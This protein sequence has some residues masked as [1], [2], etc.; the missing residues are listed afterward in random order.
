MAQLIV[1]GILLGGVYA[2]I[3][4]GLTLVFGVMRVVNFAHGDILMIAMYLAFWGKEWLHIDPYV[5][6]VLLAALFFVLCMTVLRPFIL[7]LTRISHL[8][9]TFSLLGV[10]I[11]LQNLALMLW[12]ADF[13]FVTTSYSSTV[14]HVGTV[15]L[16]LARLV[17]FVVALLVALAVHLFI[18]RTTLGRAIRATAQDPRVAAL[19]GVDVNYVYAF[20]FAL[21]VALAALAGGIMIPVFYVYP[22]VG[23]EMGIIGF[24]VIVLGGLGS[25]PGAVLAGLLIGVVE[26]FSGF[27]IAENLKQLVYF[28]VFIAILVSRPSGLFGQRGAE[29]YKTQ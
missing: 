13:R 11:A 20:T 3:A 29:E 24:V 9:Q 21:S 15:G 1:S 18:S 27:W 6:A 12:S 14:L 22:T 23:F 25:V 17:A 8:A 2:L 19:M 28:A 4:L 10:S 26:T 16:P 7:R 5:S